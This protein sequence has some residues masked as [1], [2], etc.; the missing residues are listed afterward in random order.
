MHMPFWGENALFL[1]VRT[2]NVELK[3]Y[4]FCVIVGAQHARFNFI[5]RT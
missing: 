3:A 2:F 1:L 5:V 4:A